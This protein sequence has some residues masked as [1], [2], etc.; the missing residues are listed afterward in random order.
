METFVRSIGIKWQMMLILNVEK[1]KWN[2]ERYG[3]QLRGKPSTW[4]FYNDMERIIGKTPKVI[5]LMKGYNGKEWVNLD[6]STTEKETEEMG[7]S[8]QEGS[9]MNM[10]DIEEEKTHKVLCISLKQ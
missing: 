1:Y 10:E 9:S 5:G 8:H 4:N 2:G 7:K 6:T 3:K